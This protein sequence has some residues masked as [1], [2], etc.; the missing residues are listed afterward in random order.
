M[1]GEMT[2]FFTELLDDFPGVNFLRA[3]HR[4]FHYGEEQFAA[5]KAVAEEMLPIMRREAFWEKAAVSGDEG[6]R[7]DSG[8]AYEEVAMSLGQGI[9]DLQDAYSRKGML[10]ES[11]MLETLASELLMQGYSA[12]NRLVGAEGTWHVARYH[13][14]GSEAA[15]PLEMLPEMLRKLSGRVRCNSCFYMEPKKSVAFVAELT[16]DE[17]RRCEGICIGCG[18]ADCPNR[19]EADSHR[20]YLGKVAADLPLSYGYSRILGRL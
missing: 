1:A 16:R 12:Y 18:S 14:P 19:T 8:V 20:G 10:L 2:A 15:F 9:D 11:Y 5:L 6:D 17:K 4:K 3:V 7:D 13:F